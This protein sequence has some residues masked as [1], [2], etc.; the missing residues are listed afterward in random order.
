MRKLILTRGTPGAGK[1]TLLQALGLGPFTLSMDAIR[2]LRSSPILLNNGQVGINQE[3]NEAVATEYRKLALGRM[4]RGELLALDATMPTQ[5]DLTPWLEAAKEARYEVALLDF[6]ALPLEV[7]QERNRRRE[8]ILRVSDSA[9]DRIHRLMQPSV[10][11]PG[12]LVV[13][14]TDTEAAL[15]QMQAWLDVPVRDFSNYRKVVHIGDLQGCLSV[16]V[17]PGGPLEHGFED[18]VA[19]VFVGDLVDRGIENG[20]LMRWILDNAA[21]RPNVFFLWGNHEDHLNRFAQGKPAVSAEFR[22]RTQPQLEAAGVTPAEVD[23]LCAQFLEVLPYQWNGQKVMVTHAGL[24][25]VPERF[26]DVSLSQYS[27]G[28]GNYEDPVGRQF[29]RYAPE[30]WV[31]VHGHRNYHGDPIQASTRSF[32]LEESVE[33]G[34][35]LRCV[36]LDDN[37]WTPASYRNP[38]Y[39]AARN[40]PLNIPPGVDKG[41]NR[42]DIPLAHLPP[43]WMNRASET[44][45]DDGTMEAMR[46]HPGVRQGTSKSHPHVVALNFTKDVFFQASWDDLLIKARGLFINRETQEVVA[47]GYEKFF[48][49][50]ERPETQMDQ[51][52]AN[53]KWPVTAFVKENGYLGNIGYDSETDELF[54]ASKSTPDGDF[55]GWL[56]EIFE[57]TVPAGTRERIRRWLRDNE[58]SMVF[59]VI[60]PVRDPH[61]IDYDHAHLVLLDVFHRSAHPEKLP[62]EH[63]KAIGERFGLEVKRRAMEFKTAQAFEGWHNAACSDL[64]WRYK[65]GE[66][67]EGLVLEDRAGFQTKVK[68]PH[69]S[70]WKRMR[71]AKD[72]MAGHLAKL[73]TMDDDG[74][75]KEKDALLERMAKAKALIKDHRGEG[76]QAE[77]AKVQLREMGQD[78]ALL[79]TRLNDRDRRERVVEQVDAIVARDPHPLAQ[80]F[81][82]WCRDQPAQRLANSS[83]LELRAG[84]VQ[85]AQPNPALWQERWTAFDNENEGEAPRSKR[86]GPKP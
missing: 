10:S 53:M 20:T 5:A 47:R 13:D 51:L 40:R 27:R 37:G 55:A 72:R 75:D 14:A 21:D 16:L 3:H 15:A 1:T 71:S 73:E 49:V 80:A 39:A 84:F 7:T 29:E 61:M 67:I 34:G 6:S 66:D 65:G 32:N 69:Y 86:R 79:N 11:A 62:Y 4:A 41:K 50:N 82:T 74:L 8:K 57:S 43:E 17:G 23:A 70:F 52:M 54:I 85:E 2:Q 63:L 19:Y 64:N 45:M 25:S 76:P 78:L 9:V 56:R 12:A 28:T 83:I 30:G 59:E 31:Q 58:A 77:E 22:D 24:A 42:Q 68:L 60:D 44:R 18:D 26:A 81:L 38:V 36:T 35:Y 33:F 48:N 46:S